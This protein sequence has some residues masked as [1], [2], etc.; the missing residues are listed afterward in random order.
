MVPLLS[1][2]NGLQDIL[3]NA[4]ELVMLL[5]DEHN[6]TGRL[7]VEARRHVLDSLCNNLLESIVRDGRLLGEVVD[8][9]SVLDSLAEGELAGHGC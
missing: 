8:G 6:K 9:A 3:D 4:P 2:D 1:W 7:R 5:L